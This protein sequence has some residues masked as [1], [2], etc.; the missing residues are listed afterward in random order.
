MIPP[1]SSCGRQ[2]TGISCKR[3]HRRA[4]N[5]IHSFDN[6]GPRAGTF[7]TDSGSLPMPRTPRERKFLLAWREVVKELV[8]AMDVALGIDR[9]NAPTE[10]EH[11]SGNTAIWKDDAS[12]G[13]S[14]W[15]LIVRAYEDNDE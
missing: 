9:T 7:I 10:R 14:S 2:F 3:C 8:A 12:G 5:R 6:D 4:L 1:C 15:D 13:S 11:C